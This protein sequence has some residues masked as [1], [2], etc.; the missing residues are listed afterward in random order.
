VLRTEDWYAES[1]AVQRDTKH[2][3]LLIR[4]YELDPISAMPRISVAPKQLRDAGRDLAEAFVSTVAEE[5][6]WESKARST[7]Q[8]RENDGCMSSRLVALS[9]AVPGA[10]VFAWS[11]RAQRRLASARASRLNRFAIFTIGSTSPL[12]RRTSKFS[13][14]TYPCA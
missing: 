6:I 7:A 8:P 14:E 2:V 4:K 12:P 10:T 1:E 5:V 3:C 13:S 9:L 11:A